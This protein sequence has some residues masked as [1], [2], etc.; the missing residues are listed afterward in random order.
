MVQKTKLVLLK[1]K[2]QMRQK[3]TKDVIEEKILNL[4]K[5][6]N[7]LTERIVSPSKNLYKMIALTHPSGTNK[8]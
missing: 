7:L 6:L 1:T 3:K 8:I 4:E 5:D 2:E